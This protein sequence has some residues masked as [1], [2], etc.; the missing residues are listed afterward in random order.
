MEKELEIS[1]LH[2]LDI[3]SRESV[4]D[5]ASEYVEKLKNMSKHFRRLHITIKRVHKREK[6]EKYEVHAKLFDKTPVTSTHTE[7][8]LFT[9][10]Q[11]V[12]G[13]VRQEIA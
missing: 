10:L 8:N 13:H 3:I 6:S 2:N 4:E 11:N 9:C 7:Y 1:G 5:M 12:L